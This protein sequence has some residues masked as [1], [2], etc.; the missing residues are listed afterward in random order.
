MTLIAADDRRGGP[1]DRRDLSRENPGRRAEDKARVYTRQHKVD[2][3]FCGW[4][5]SL[6]ISRGSFRSE[7]NPMTKAFDRPRMCVR[8]RQVFETEEHVKQNYL[9][10]NNI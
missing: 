7:H 1:E 6:V 5:D 9:K 10:P 8:C 3:P 2:C 4:W